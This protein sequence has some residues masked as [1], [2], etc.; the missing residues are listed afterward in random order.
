MGDLSEYKIALGAKLDENVGNDI[1][2]QL[3]ELKSLKIKISGVELDNS[4]ISRQLQGLT[5]NFTASY[6]NMAKQASS[7]F[8]ANFK[9]NFNESYIND[10]AAKLKQ[11]GVNSSGI[12][13]MVKQ[14]DN[15]N[16][17]ITNIK[18]TMKDGGQFS[19]F[20]ITGLDQLGRTVNYIANLNSSGTFDFTKTVS[21]SFQTL[22]QSAR[23]AEKQLNQTYSIFAKYNSLNNQLTSLYDKANL[24]GNTTELQS[25]LTQINQLQTKLQELANQENYIDQ[26]SGFKQMTIEISNVKTQLDSYLRS[27][28]EANKTELFDTKKVKSV[29]QVSRYLEENSKL[30]KTNTDEAKELRQEIVLLQEQMNNAT[31]SSE[32]QKYANQFSVLKSQVQSAGLEG[33]K[34]SDTIANDVKKFGTWLIAGN[35]FMNGY[36]AITGTIENIF[37]L[38]SAM[39]ELKKVTDETSDTYENFYYTAN[40]TAK[41]LGQTTSQV[42][43]N[44][45]SIAQLGYSL[46]EATQ[47]AEYAA[48]F[49]TISPE[50]NYDDA[51]DGIIAVIKAYQDIDVDEVGDEIISKINE[52]GNTFAVNNNDILE[53]LKDSASALSVARNSLDETIALN[54]AGTEVTRDAS[55]VANAL[56]TI[57]MRVRGVDA[58]TGQLKEDL[59]LMNDQVNAITNKKIEFF[60]DDTE[61][62]F[63]S[64]YEIL[65]Q[66][67]DI[68]PTLNDKARANI[69]KIVAGKTRANELAA[70][71]NN[72]ESA[73]KV[74]EG[75]QDSAGSMDREFSKAQDSLQYKLNKT[76]ETL[77]GMGQT[78]IDD[79]ALK[80]GLDLLNGILSVLDKIIDKMGSLGTVMTGLGIY[81]ATKG[82]GGFEADGK[83][84][85]FNKNATTLGTVKSW[86]NGNE[87]SALVTSTM[88]AFNEKV[89]NGNLNVQQFAASLEQSGNILSGFFKN[90]DSGVNPSLEDLSAYASQ[91]GAGLKIASIG[92]TA[93]NIALNVGVMLA[94]TAAVKG[95]A[96]VIDVLWETWKE[97]TEQAQASQEAYE[98][99]TKSLEDIN[100]QLDEN[101]SKMD[102]LLSK[103]H[104]SYTDQE[105]IAKLKESNLELQ[106]QLDLQEKINDQAKRDSAEDSLHVLD[107]GNKYSFD[108]DKASENGTRN[109]INDRSNESV[110]KGLNVSV[111]KDISQN[112]T[113]ITQLVSAY[114]YLTSKS[115]E[116]N[117]NSEAWLKNNEQLVNVD[118]LLTDRMSD[119]STYL[120][121]AKDEYD[122]LLQKQQNGGFLSSADQDLINTYDQYQ[123]VLDQLYQLTMPEQWNQIKFDEIFDTSGIELTKEQL[124]E[125][126][127]AGKLDDLDLSKYPE[128]Y[129]AIN[130]VGLVCGDNETAVESFKN[131]IESLTGENTFDEAFLSD[132]WDKTNAVYDDLKDNLTELA[133]LQDAL[134][135]SFQLSAE[136]ARK[137]GEVYPEILN[138]G[139]ITSDGL[140]SLNADEAQAFIDAKEAEA[141]ASSNQQIKELEGRR[142]V[143]Q[144]LLAAAQAEL[145]SVQES[146]KANLSIEEAKNKA[147]AAGQEELTKYMI[148][149]G[150]DEQNANKLAV[151]TMDG[152]MRNYSKTVSDVAT[153][154]E[155]NLSN[156]LANAADSSADNSKIMSDNIN[157]VNTTAANTGSIISTIFSNIISDLQ[158]AFSSPQALLKAI[159]GSGGNPIIFAIRSGWNTLQNYNGSNVSFNRGV[160]GGSRSTTAGVGRNKT[161]YSGGSDYTITSKYNP[162]SYDTWMADLEGTISNYQ[163]AIDNINGQIN[164]LEAGVKSPLSNFSSGKYKDKTSSSKSPS[165][166]TSK[167]KTEKEFSKTFDWLEIAIQR[168]QDKIEQLS[169]VAS[170]VYEAWST[171]N[172][173]LTE[174]ITN[175]ADKIELESAAYNRYMAQAESIGLSE[176]YKNLVKNG[177]IDITTITDETLANQIEA[178]QTWYDKATESAKAIRDLEQELSKAFEEKFNNIVTVYDDKLSMIEFRTSQLQKL[179]DINVNKGYNSSV[180]YYKE[181]IALETENVKMLEEQ[182]NALNEQLDEMVNSGAIAPFSESWYDLVQQIQNVDSAI[183]DATASLVD[184]SNQMRQI[185]WDLFDYMQDTISQITT[186]GKFLQDLLSNKTLFD[187][188]GNKNN[189]ANSLMGLYG[190]NWNTY[191]QQSDNYAKAIKD[192]DDQFKNDSLNKDYLERRQQLVEL[193]QQAIQSAN[194]EKQAM[195]DLERKAYD[196]QLEY[197]NKLI[198]ARKDLL[199]TEKE[200]Y[201][202][203]KKVAEQ[204][205]TIQDLQKQYIANTGNDSE[206]GQ[207][208]LQDLKNQL[209]EAKDNLQETEYDRYISDQEAMLDQFYSDLELFVSEKFDNVD[210]WFSDLVDDVNSNANQIG[211]TI[212]DETTKLGYTL[213]DSMKTIFDTSSQNLGNDIISASNANASGIRGLI[214]N[215]DTNFSTRFTTL[216]TA[217]DKITYF[218]QALK[219]KS[220]EE[221]RKAAEAARKAAEEQQRKAE[222]AK[223]KAEEEAKRKAAEEEAKRK[224][225]QAAAANK[226][227]N[228]SSSSSSSSSKGSF[229]VYERNYYPTNKLNKETSIIDRLKLNNFSTS[230]SNMAKY[231]QGMGLG[232]A[233]S[234]TGSYSQNVAMLNWMKANGFKQSGQLSS[235]I[236]T[237][238]EDGL[239]LGRKDDI[240]IRPEEWDK[241]L[242]IAKEVNDYQSILN[243]ANNSHQATIISI[244]K[245]ELPNV[246]NYDEFK[247][248]LLSDPD[249]SKYIRNET[250]IGLGMAN[251]LSSSRFRK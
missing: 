44:T 246:E 78:I 59:L 137:F 131:Q 197:I 148:G 83:N 103:D 182:K 16:I 206:E 167:E 145:Q 223:R 226:N 119:I 242:D 194:D 25:F 32:L 117:G 140:I 185:E 251:S 141:E 222:E 70:I 139:Q 106:K 153:D 250:K 168:V 125:L 187:E 55:R 43:S 172:N 173:G 105:E 65:K 175:I 213:S 12:S 201:E 85:T 207:K 191:M 231:Y 62:T 92:A 110:I 64:T 67:Y 75:I 19:G 151:E 249:L 14:L 233:S 221:A 101:K 52:I 162:T 198:D 114:D 156:G 21:Q 205:K 84:I 11:M 89:T 82:I 39:T 13:S 241:I 126:A 238:K 180:E 53:G 189:Y 154:S 147:Q 144:G 48:K 202:F 130:N 229:F 128:L 244:D 190:I 160:G 220:D 102:E 94:F 41:M 166:K 163:N 51:T 98:A 179:M 127:E 10:F 219:E 97:A 164:L 159:I 129:E 237:A 15:L 122:T 186:E 58:E 54:V 86:L 34:Y 218:V 195:I 113:S 35:M 203:Q 63:K 28:R 111:G 38:D 196:A 157:Q 142:A 193:Q 149:L 161:I 243:E 74:M 68:W 178:Y 183:T 135:D 152:N 49:S 212:T 40:D 33:Q 20:N 6:S 37:E 109:D 235:M 3:N 240:I 108:V 69:L 230:W 121:N 30:M 46:Q 23:E 174:E 158:K 42:I 227:N 177:A 50:L 96:T 200:L 133:D 60:T 236:D 99:S 47:L 143:L 90:L 248:G 211:T 150:I 76:K 234:Y 71:L 181:L 17:S 80:H 66:I 199:N 215:Y 79:D 188:V 57:S 91:A 2:S 165:S 134:G 112:N 36:R 239:F 209:Q 1:Q 5:Q 26:A 8:N 116:L 176:Y 210:Q 118:K 88:D 217:V 224:A 100:T 104:L 192:L 7:A 171:R 107:K 123:E 169:S 225:Q 73:E 184:F 204:T 87:N 9:L 81:K 138:M 124:I 77:A 170:N 115:E 31:N 214:S 228:S 72:F 93:L 146:A 18:H 29:T 208:T 232:S 56:R 95:L 216:Q 155:T 45:A 120:G 247:N 245:I 27:A 4:T 136:E 61:Q 132:T 24:A 22:E